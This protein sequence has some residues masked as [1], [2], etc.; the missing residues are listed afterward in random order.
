MMSEIGEAIHEKCLTFG[1]R[2]IKLNCY[3]LIKAANA[4]PPYKIAGGK[5]VYEKAV[6]GYLQSI[7]ALCNQLLRSGTRSV[8]IG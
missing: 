1:D 2:V 8:P 5:R 4:K 7:S 6:P 3:L